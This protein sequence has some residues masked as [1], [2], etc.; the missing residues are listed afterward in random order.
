MSHFNTRFKHP[1]KF[2]K[3]SIEFNEAQIQFMV[4]IIHKQE[5]ELPPSRIRTRAK[6]CELISIFS[7]SLSQFSKKADDVDNKG[8]L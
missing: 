4:S 2:P 7:K 6:C 1:E 8:V 5:H 3:I